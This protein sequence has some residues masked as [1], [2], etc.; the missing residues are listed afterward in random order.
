VACI[1]QG[2]S[3]SGVAVMLF[4][5]KVVTAPSKR[6]LLSFLCDAM[7]CDAIDLFIDF[8]FVFSYFFW[9]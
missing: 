9:P 2:N 5:M 6:P 1:E 7:R 4:L 3:E 8:L